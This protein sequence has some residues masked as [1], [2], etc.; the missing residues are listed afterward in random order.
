M[1]V[2]V[3]FCVDLLLTL[4][5]FYARLVVAILLAVTYDLQFNIFFQILQ[6]PVVDEDSSS[7]HSPLVEK[8][9]K[10]YQPASTPSL[11]L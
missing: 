4:R 7:L 8:S 11:G 5:S 6:A 3:F 9:F 10:R 1:V 2:V